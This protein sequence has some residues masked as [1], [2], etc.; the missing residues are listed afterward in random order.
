MN[1]TKGTTMK[2]IK[3]AKGE[4]TTESPSEKLGLNLSVIKNEDN[5]WAVVKEAEI[6]REY[7]MTADTKREA[8]EILKINY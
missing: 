7:I 8:I 6:E 4:Y 2:L 3:I 5:V 1:K